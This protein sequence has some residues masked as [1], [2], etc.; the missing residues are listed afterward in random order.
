M[1]PVIKQIKKTLESDTIA[2]LWTGGWDSTFRL[3]QLLYIEKRE[4]QPIYIIELEHRF[5]VYELMAMNEIRSVLKKKGGTEKLLRPTIYIDQIDIET[6][7]GILKAWEKIKTKR[8]L[9]QQYVWLSS[10]CKQYE[11][12][13]VELSIEKDSEDSSSESI[14]CYLTESRMT[15]DIRTIFKY[16]SLPLINMTRK[17][18]RNIIEMKNWSDIMDLT[19]FCHH[20]IYHPFKKGV[21]C[22]VCNPCRITV[23]EGLGHRIPFTFRKSGKYLK[24]IYNSSAMHFLR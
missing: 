4:V 5:P 11:L 23:E 2:L 13:G 19:W 22:G 16:F 24:R 18:M 1:K 3:L 20:P 15:P 7:E 17:D 9:G 14:A 12:E 8:H 10:L 21:P 6:D